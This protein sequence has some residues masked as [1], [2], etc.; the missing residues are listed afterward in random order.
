[1]NSG[2]DWVEQ[3]G[4]AG[5]VW[6]AIASSSNGEKLV[7]IG[8]DDYS[9]NGG[10]IYTSQDSGATWTNKTNPTG[11]SP[12]WW[13]RIASSADGEKLAAAVEG[14]YIYTSADSGA[15][16]TERTGA[17][18]HGWGAIASSADGTKLVAA[19][20]YDASSIYTSPDGGASWTEQ[21]ID[22][23]VENPNFTG[24]ACSSD[25]TKLALVVEGGY[26]YTAGY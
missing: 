21:V 10:A 22:A 9:G 25:G 5:K 14:G 4:S 7:A 6:T 17:G 19:P 20:R 26:I 16:W 8:Y 1:M 23:G 13:Q 15:T 18:S 2:V 3:D 12:R 11:A 24:V